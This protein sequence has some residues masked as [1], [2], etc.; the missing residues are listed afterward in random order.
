MVF[1]GASNG[2]W[3]PPILQSRL[4]NLGPRRYRVIGADYRHAL[5][6]GAPLALDINVVDR[7]PDSE[8]QV[9][10]TARQRGLELYELIRA[11]A[12]SADTVYFY[13]ANTLEDSDMKLAACA[14]A[15]V[16][17]T[18]LPDGQARYTAARPLSW[19]VDTRGWDAYLDGRPWPCLADDRVLL[20]AG[21]HTVCLRRPA[22]D[23][24][25]ALHVTRL[26]GVLLDARRDGAACILTYRS[27]WRCYVAFDGA[28]AALRCEGQP[29]ELPQGATEAVLPP[30]THSIEA[31]P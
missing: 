25:P 17:V 28:P 8:A 13:A 3:C 20:P 27:P 26:S 31:A 14:A 7:E 2:Q 9:L 16:A 12:E 21:T 18:A 30:G 22:A 29:V 5:A 15:L 1:Q 24:P 23:A 10:V 6:E 19:L 4:R 11:A